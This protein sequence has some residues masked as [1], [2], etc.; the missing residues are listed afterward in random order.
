V[1]EGKPEWVKESSGDHAQSPDGGRTV[2]VVYEDEGGAQGGFRA[3][4]LEMVN[5]ADEKTTAIGRLSAGPG[6][7]GAGAW[8]PDGKR[9]AFVSYHWV[10][11]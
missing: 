7:L 11:E 8:S 1:L 4:V 6:T 2:T 3:A 10:W 9:V 5:Q